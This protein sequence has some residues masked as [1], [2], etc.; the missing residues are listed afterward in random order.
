VIISKLS[1]FQKHKTKIIYND[2]ASPAV[3]HGSKSWT[4]KAK[5]QNWNY[6]CGMANTLRWTIK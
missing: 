3:L 5:R 2:L 6:C 1:K 4:M